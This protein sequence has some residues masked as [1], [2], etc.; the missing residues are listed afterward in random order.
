VNYV[1]AGLTKAVRTLKSQALKSWIAAILIAQLGLAPAAAYAGTDPIQ[2]DSGITLNDLIQEITQDAVP[3]GAAISLGVVFKAAK[4]GGRLAGVASFLATT[5]ATLPVDA[6]DNAIDQDNDR[7]DKV[8]DQY[9]ERLWSVYVNDP[10]VASK[11]RSILNA[12]ADRLNQACQQKK[13]QCGVDPSSVF[14]SQKAGDSFQMV[15]GRPVWLLSADAFVSADPVET[16]SLELAKLVIENQV[17][18]R[19]IDVQSALNNDGSTRRWYSLEDNK[20]SYSN[21]VTV[22]ASRLIDPAPS[23][24]SGGTFAE[25][26]KNYYERFIVRERDA[27]RWTN[28]KEFE[29]RYLSYRIQ[30][31]PKKNHETVLTSCGLSGTENLFADHLASCKTILGNEI[32]QKEILDRIASLYTKYDSIKGWKERGKDYGKLMAEVGAGILLAIL[33]HKT[34][35]VKIM[36]KLA[37]QSR[38]AKFFGSGVRIMADGLAFW[39]GQSGAE[40]AIGSKGAKAELQLDQ[41]KEQEYLNMVLDYTSLA[42]QGTL[43]PESIKLFENQIQGM[44]E[45]KQAPPATLTNKDLTPSS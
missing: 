34:V 23:M 18:G 8:T 43:T 19:Y 22:A 31:M 14:I 44:F 26:F 30:K 35:G 45:S 16:L 20:M 39:A 17:P 5:L 4:T 15:N 37:G 9:Y 29:Q 27:K 13:S 38:W 2:V 36:A 42:Q 40:W 24:S 6:L 11:G 33:I 21:A 25:K 7:R 10:D 41:T 12:A 28:Q 3:I 1:M 32:F